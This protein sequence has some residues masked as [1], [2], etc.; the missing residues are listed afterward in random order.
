MLTYA[1]KRERERGSKR[2]RARAREKVGNCLRYTLYLLY[3]HKTGTK[4]QIL[5]PEELQRKREGRKGTG[6]FF[7]ALLVQTGTKAQILTPEE[8]Q[9]KRERPWRK[10]K[11]TAG[12]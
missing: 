11:A 8:L 4:A 5:T 6:N 1:G 2:A 7:F 12:P 3:W 10:R 9:R